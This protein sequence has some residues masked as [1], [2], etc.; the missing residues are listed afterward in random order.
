[1]SCLHTFAWLLSLHIML[2][3]CVHKSSFY[4][5]FKKLMSFKIILPWDSFSIKCNTILINQVSMCTFLT[6]HSICNLRSRARRY[7]NPSWAIYYLWYSASSSFK[8]LAQN[9][10]HNREVKIFLGLMTNIHIYWAIMCTSTLELKCKYA[11][12]YTHLHTWT[13]INSDVSNI[14]CI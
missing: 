11:G 8:C 3:S 1:M 9:I 7:C 14:P 2:T 10:E 13:D 6:A 4:P 12:L 5:S